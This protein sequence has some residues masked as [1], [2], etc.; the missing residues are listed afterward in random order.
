MAGLKRRI[1]VGKGLPFFIFLKSAVCGAWRIIRA[2]FARVT[3]NPLCGFCLP[4]NLDGDSV[5]PCPQFM[6]IF[7]ICRLAPIKNSRSVIVLHH[8]K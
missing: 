7:Q 4:G 1:H 8:G 5:S 2:S 6:H 3:Q